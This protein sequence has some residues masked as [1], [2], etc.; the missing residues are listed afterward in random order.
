MT[1]VHIALLLKGIWPLEW[2][3][4]QSDA[5]L[6]RGRCKGCWSLGGC[7]GG[8]AAAWPAAAGASAASAAAIAGA[9]ALGRA[10]TMEQSTLRC[11]LTSSIE[12]L[13]A[14]SIGILL[15]IGGLLLA[16]S[17]CFTTGVLPDEPG[18]THNQAASQGMK[19]VGCGTASAGA[20]AAAIAG[21]TDTTT[22]MRNTLPKTSTLSAQ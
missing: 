2:R 15:S 20:C 12:T 3:L 9:A 16:S 5:H 17:Q 18:R 14:Q 1:E 11:R 22:S 13:L 6:S 7:T 21:V 19:G 8:L 4:R 10:C